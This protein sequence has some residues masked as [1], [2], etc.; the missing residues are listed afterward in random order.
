MKKSTAVKD[1]V[2]ARVF[3]KD[4]KDVFAGTD[5][6]DMGTQP[7]DADS[8]VSEGATSESLGNP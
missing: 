1:R 5:N 6:Q 2:M 3:A 8:T 4:L 7:S